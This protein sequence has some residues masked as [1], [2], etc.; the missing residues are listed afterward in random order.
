MRGAVFTFQEVD[1]KPK[2]K[3]WRFLLARA[4]ETSSWRGAILLVSG[5]L[6]AS[7]DEQLTA[8][9]VAVG[10]GLAGIV[11]MFVPDGSAGE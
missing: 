4:K 3:V 9:V 1:A 11:G 8:Y 5:L 10:V 7:V 2:A 6:G